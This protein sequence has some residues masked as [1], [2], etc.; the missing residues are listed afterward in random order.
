MVRKV[1]IRMLMMLYGVSAIIILCLGIAGPIMMA[2]GETPIWV[3]FI[4]YPLVLL[5][6]ATQDIC[7]KYFD[8]YE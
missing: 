6:C 2:D 3:Y 8:K 5:I 7:F 4:L 1:L